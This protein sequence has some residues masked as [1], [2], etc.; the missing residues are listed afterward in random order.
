MKE[1]DKKANASH[2][3][4]CCKTYNPKGRPGYIVCFR[5]SS[6][7]NVLGS[8]DLDEFL[9]NFQHNTTRPVSYDV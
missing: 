1:K 7:G 6:F 5:K 3:F 4:G 2:F 9:S 8:L